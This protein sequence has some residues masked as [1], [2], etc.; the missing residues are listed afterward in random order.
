MTWE[1]K[2]LGK[3]SRQQAY[4]DATIQTCLTMNV[5]FG[6]P[7]KQTTGFVESLLAMTGLE[8][9]VPDFNTFCRRQKTLP[10]SIPYLG[11]TGPLIP[12][13]ASLRDTLSGRR[14]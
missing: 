11:G 10:V 1:A 13:R 7:L 12:S 4:S 14:G 6:M 5:L 9:S 3:R 8:W 2:P